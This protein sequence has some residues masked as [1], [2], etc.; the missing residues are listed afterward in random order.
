MMILA[1]ADRPPEHDVLELIDKSQVELVCLLGDLEYSDLRWLESIKDIPKIGVYGNHC[2]GNYFDSLGIKNLHLK[3]FEFKGIVFG[4]FEGSIRY[5]DSSD[6]KMHTQEEAKALLKNFQKVDVMIAHSPPF[7]I[8]DEPD[9]QSHQGLMALREYI[10]T[11]KPRY[12]LH[13]HTY[14]VSKNLVTKYAGTDIIYVFGDKIIKIA[15]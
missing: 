2:S 15:E 6:A 11:R 3:T 9:S 5:K 14:P 7:G 13:G 1:I 12:F 10:K 4:G 8:N